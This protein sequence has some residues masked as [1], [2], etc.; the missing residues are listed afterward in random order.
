[1]GAPHTL[2]PVRPIRPP[3]P[4]TL[5]LVPPT[6]RPVQPTAPP[7]LPTPPR[8]PRTARPVRHTRRQRTKGG[9][10]EIHTDACITWGLRP[11]GDVSW[12]LSCLDWVMPRIRGRRTNVS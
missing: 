3:H 4:R 9:T 2:P 5:P 6:A 12:F 1:M 11:V 10:Q 8:A 7:L